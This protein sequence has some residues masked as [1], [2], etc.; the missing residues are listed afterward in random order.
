MVMQA[1]FAGGCF[2]GVQHLMA[3]VPGVLDSVV[4][5]CGGHT[6]KPSYLQVCTGKTGHLEAL[7]ISYDPSIVS[8]RSLAQ[9]FFEIHDF[10]QTNGQ[11]P[12]I[13]PQYM[14]AVF[15]QDE[16]Q[17]KV[18]QEILKELVG[19]GRHPATKILEKSTFWPAEKHHQ[20]YYEKKKSQPYCH[21]RRPLF[22]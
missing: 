4:G 11:G 16:E 20:K 6:K 18:T 17:E 9:L 10:E 22:S 21:M 12:D 1:V 2:W 19:M 14:S 13:G 5:Y 7:Q 15:P 3:N 8:F